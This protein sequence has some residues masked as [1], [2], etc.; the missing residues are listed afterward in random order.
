MGLT[1]HMGL[2][3]LMGLTISRKRSHASTDLLK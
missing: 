1:G 2:M 3:G